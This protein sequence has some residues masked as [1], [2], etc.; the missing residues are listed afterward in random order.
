ME[1]MGPVLRLSFM[2]LAAF[3]ADALAVTKSLGIKSPNGEATIAY[4]MNARGQVAAVLEDGDGNQ[5][6]VLFEHGKVT[7]LRSLGG[8]YSDAKAIN[9]KGQVVGSAQNAERRWKA[10]VFERASGLRELGTL[11][12]ENSYGMAISQGG[13]VV[14]FSDTADGFFHAYIAHHDGP[15][16]D[17]GTLGG[18][19]SYASA[20][21]SAGQVAGTASMPDEYR[22]A[23]LYDP[24]RGMLDLGTLG[25]LSSSASA[26]NDSGV[27]VGASL[28]R[29]R[30][31]HAFVHD[32]KRMIDLGAIIGRGSSFATSINNAG[33]V[34]G[35]LLIGDERQSF[36]WR[37]NKMIV[38]R[39]GKGLH[40]TNAINDKEQVI[41]ATY[42][43]RLDAATMASAAVPV[44]TRGGQ[45]LS[46]LI[47]V[48]AAGAIGVGLHRRFLG[49]RG[50]DFA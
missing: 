18:T 25:G 47:L 26:I 44:I 43:K 36:V 22:H 1:Y 29:D 14:G 48:V 45:E 4:D 34:V 19:I 42:D 28:T 30:R 32:G 17:L 24:V 9:E 41:G 7:E 8:G 21:N 10:F 15:M 33:H 35:T 5:R 20:V 46:T 6:G 38:H 27:I 13:D 16:K 2:L 50:P 23:F 39:G 11:G 49:A 40:L 3:A 37:D 31:W 12:G